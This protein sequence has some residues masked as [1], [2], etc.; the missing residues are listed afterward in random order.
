[1]VVYKNSRTM[2]RIRIAAA[3]LANEAEL[4]EAVAWIV[5][6]RFE[7]VESGSVEF[8]RWVDTRRL[9]LP[10]PAPSEAATLIDEAEMDRRR[11]ENW[12]AAGIDVDEAEH[13]PAVPFSRGR[14]MTT[15]HQNEPSEVG[16]P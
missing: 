4:S 8:M 6:Q 5:K 7:H 14:R 15:E 9:A 12:R 16:T 2:H 11:R 13:L 1:M 3:G 10:D